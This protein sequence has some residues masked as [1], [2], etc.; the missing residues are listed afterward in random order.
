[1]VNLFHGQCIYGI[2]QFRR[3]GAV[4]LPY[5]IMKKVYL[6]NQP[7]GPYQRY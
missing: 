6:E 7:L 3:R 5:T 4:L 2:F 1:M